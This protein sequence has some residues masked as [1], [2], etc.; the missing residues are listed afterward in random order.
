MSDRV[1][2]FLL[3]ACFGSG[4]GSIRDGNEHHILRCMHPLN[5]VLIEQ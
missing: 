2:N 3:A 4:D 5:Q 1:K